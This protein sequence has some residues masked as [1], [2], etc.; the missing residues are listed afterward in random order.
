MS[1]DA[2]PARGRRDAAVT[3]TDEVVS[4]FAETRDPRLRE[5]L[6]S[7]VHHLHAFA[8]EVQLSEREWHQ[9]VEFLTR[10]GHTTTDDRQEFILLSDVLGLSMLTIGLNQPEGG[11]VTEA[12]VFGPF[13][14]PGS[15][16][17]PLGG[18]VAGDPPGEPCWLEGTVRDEEGRPVAGARVEVWQADDEGLYDVQR[19]GA[20]TSGRGHLF[21]DEQGG[22]RFWTVRP[23][24]YPI[25][26]DGPVGDLLRATGR[27]PMRPAH[28]H[29]M[30]SAD[31]YRTLVTHVFAA[32]DPHMATDA[33]FG[34]RSSLITEFAERAPGPAPDGSA[35][36]APWYE[37][38]FDFVLAR[39]A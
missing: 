22:Y 2:V 21:T 18:D 37:A 26:D 12:T 19:E 31:G 8:E 6:S 35:M 34:V 32:G 28:V 13:F 39:D 29:F 25:P 27:S 23:S 24:P 15:P 10:V 14:V 5:V 17:I 20:P 1:Q 7:L 4:S 11:G 16:R 30:I 9:A 36:E 38:S 33:V 3:V